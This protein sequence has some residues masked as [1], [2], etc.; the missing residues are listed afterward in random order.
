MVS[1]CQNISDMIPE[2]ISKT[3]TKKQ[4]AE[5][6]RHI[7]SCLT[8]RADFALWLSVDRSLKQ[9]EKTVPAIN[10][11]AMTA[12]EKI[13]ESGSYNMA[14]DIIRYVFGTVKTTHR[15]ASLLT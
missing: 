10:L 1:D 11:Q 6:A 12:L 5:I 8:C 13:I 3:T 2:Y 9:T 14:F 4:N 15:L 7:S